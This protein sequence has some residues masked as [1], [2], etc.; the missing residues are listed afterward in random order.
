MQ[1]ASRLNISTVFLASIAAGLEYYD[2]LIYAYMLPFFSLVIFPP[3]QFAWRTG[4][5][6]FSVGMLLR[7]VGAFLWGYIADIFGRRTGLLAIMFSL[8]ASIILM[9][10]LP[11]YA[12]I[13]LAAPILFVALRLLQSVSFGADLPCGIV[14][15]YEHA[16]ATKSGLYTGIM[17]ANVGVGAALAAAAG[18]VLTILFSHEQML[19]A[20]R[21]AFLFG[22][23]LAVVAIMTRKKLAE[24]PEFIV[25]R[26]EKNNQISFLAVLRGIGVLLLPATMVMLNTSFPVL[27]H[28]KYHY[29][30][31][32]IYKEMMLVSFISAAFIVLFAYLGDKYG[33]MSIFTIAC[34]FTALIVGPAFYGLIPLHTAWALFCFLLLYHFALAMLAGVFFVHLAAMFA[35]RV[36][37]RSYTLCY[38]IVYSVLAVVPFAVLHL[39]NVG[40]VLC[41]V[42][43]MLSLLAWFSARQSHD[44]PLF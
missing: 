35:V 8:S 36:R 10:V 43:P 4:M 23:A 6:W 13:G 17:A 15:L 31:A 11:G 27:L 25:R 29:A 40:V 30:V 7:P 18:S 28:H 44:K 24:S 32:L 39:N 42:L 22:G 3:G 5:L 12:A 19:W 14:F 20:W 1:T 38:N 26:H 34:A 37:A 16:P 21:L 9:A 2:F 33:R 41:S